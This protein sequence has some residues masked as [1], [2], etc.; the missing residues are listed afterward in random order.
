MV[1]VIIIFLNYRIIIDLNR[2]CSKKSRKRRRKT[3]PQP[4]S[5]SKSTKKTIK[6]ILNSH[7]ICTSLKPPASSSPPKMDNLSKTI[8]W[9]SPLPRTEWAK[10]QLNKM[11]TIPHSTPTTTHMSQH[12][13]NANQSNQKTKTAT[14][15]NSSTKSVPVV[16][17]ASGRSNKRKTATSTQWNKYQK[18]STYQITPESS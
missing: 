12:P 3:P 11:P 9:P 6:S 8:K 15:T 14:T 16:L 7:S 17:A 1:V 4:T 2:K 18:Q 5:S 13:S 10:N